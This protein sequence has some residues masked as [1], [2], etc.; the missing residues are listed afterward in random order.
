MTGNSERDHLK[1]ALFLC[2]VHMSRLGHAMLK[3]EH[4]FPLNI[5]KLINLSDDELSFIDQMIFR[6]GKLQDTMGAKLFALLLLNLGED[7]EG[8]PFIDRLS[9]LEK[10]AFLQDKNEWLILRE[11]RNIVSHEYPNADEQTIN[12]LNQLKEHVL[13]LQAIFQGLKES[14]EERFH[15]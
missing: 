5:E 15:F 10:L 3:T 1:Q 7:I 12:G 6:F 11:T 2:E 13:K 14:I 9:L 4:L 8:L